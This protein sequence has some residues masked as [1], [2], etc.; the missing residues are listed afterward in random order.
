MKEKCKWVKGLKKLTREELIALMFCIWD[1][2][3]K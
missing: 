1:L 2:L 3:R